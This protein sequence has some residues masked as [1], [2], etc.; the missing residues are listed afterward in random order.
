MY[1]Q[2]TGTVVAELA[3]VYYS[4]STRA[5]EASDRS[6]D[7][8]FPMMERVRLRR[9]AMELQELADQALR[10]INELTVDVAA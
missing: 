7:T 4:A 8:Q 9:K 3:N 2:E 10:M 5:K 6:Q 1:A